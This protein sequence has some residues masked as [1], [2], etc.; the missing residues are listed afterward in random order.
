M[1]L[2]KPVIDSYY[3]CHLTK[4]S[5]LMLD[6]ITLTFVRCSL[7]SKKIASPASERGDLFRYSIIRFS[8]IPSHI[9]YRLGSDFTYRSDNVISFMM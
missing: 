8:V 9:S 1:Q 5:T 7:R 3:R 6:N 4:V 2:L